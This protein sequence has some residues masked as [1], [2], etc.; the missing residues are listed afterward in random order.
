MAWPPITVINKW[1]INSQVQ[2]VNL[3]KKFLHIFKGI[4]VGYVVK[5]STFK[6]YNLFFWYLVKSFTDL[7]CIVMKDP[8]SALIIDTEKTKV[9]EGWQ[10]LH[11]RHQTLDYPSC[12]HNIEYVILKWWSRSVKYI[13]EWVFLFIFFCF[14]G[15]RKI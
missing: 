9:E 4:F 7:T 3:E 15:M 8:T 10:S 5:I 11:L 1:W 2:S 12:F 14:L 6:K 13:G